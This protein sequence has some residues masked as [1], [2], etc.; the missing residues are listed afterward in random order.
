[1][2]T[3]LPENEPQRELALETYGILDT[4][5]EIAYDELA[6]LAAQICGCSAG[7][8]T[9]L[10]DKRQWIKAKCGLPPDLT[11]VPKEIS[12]CQATICNNDL[13]YVPDLTKDPRF[14]NSPL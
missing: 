12:V 4:P 10:D 7:L 6:D 11:H 8:L 5:P 13:V 1:M 14:C 9:F 3:Y 2:K